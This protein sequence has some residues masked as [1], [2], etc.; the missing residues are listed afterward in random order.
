MRACASYARCH[1]HPR[2]ISLR[3][4]SWMNPSLIM[5]MI[6]FLHACGMIQIKWM[7]LAELVESYL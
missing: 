1:R 3:H 7:Q 6:R 4:G 5:R 2:L